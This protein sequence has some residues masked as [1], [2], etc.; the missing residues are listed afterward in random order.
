[1]VS[2]STT[3]CTLGRPHRP[4]RRLPL[5]TMHFSPWWLPSKANH[6]NLDKIHHLR[7]K[8]HMW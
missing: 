3:T 4:F 1:M 6:K 2:L 5:H 8:K 7:A